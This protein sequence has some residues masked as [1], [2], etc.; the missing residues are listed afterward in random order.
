VLRRLDCDDSFENDAAKMGTLTLETAGDLVYGSFDR[1]T[2][3]DDRSI[4]NGTN[5]GVLFTSEFGRFANIERSFDLLA[6]GESNKKA[7]F[8]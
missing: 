5:F 6:L 1:R 8:G 4:I 2:P 7:L 3:I